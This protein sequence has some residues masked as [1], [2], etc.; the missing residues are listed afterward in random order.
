MN[1]NEIIE[2]VKELVFGS[3]ESK[4]TFSEAVLKNGV[5]IMTPGDEFEVGAEV[6]VVGEGENTPAPDGE[7]ELEDGTVVIT[8]DG[9]ITE[10][11]I[12]EDV[13]PEV[14]VEIEAEEKEKMESDEEK[15][16]EMEEEVVEEVEEDLK[17]KIKALEEKLKEMEKNQE[18]LINEKLNKVVEATEFLVD[19]FSKMPG[20]DKVEIKAAGLKSETFKKSGSKAER[21][22][23]LQETLKRID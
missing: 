4:E 22:R 2:K 14:E 15:E 11:K 12:A 21:L 19:E 9:K 7:H 10:I 20:G 8:E 23:E 5:K 13:E 18:K 6:L 1:K 17:E 3:E 16:D